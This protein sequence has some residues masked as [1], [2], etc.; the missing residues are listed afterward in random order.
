MKLEVE[1]RTRGWHADSSF[2]F[3]Q[4]REPAAR[5]V[6]FRFGAICYAAVELVCA[7]LRDEEDVMEAQSVDGD[8]RGRD[9]YQVVA[10]ELFTASISG[11]A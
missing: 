2:L 1:C 3:A 8:W 9:V 7:I 5:F 6:P 11:D 4:D 10:G